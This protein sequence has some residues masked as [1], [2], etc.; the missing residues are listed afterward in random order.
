VTRTNAFGRLFPAALFS[1]LAVI[2]SVLWR[3]DPV[4]MAFGVC[5]AGG[6]A[7]WLILTTVEVVR[8]LRVEPPSPVETPASLRAG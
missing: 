3:P 1:I 5:A 7:A 4:L 2:L 6:C 8:G